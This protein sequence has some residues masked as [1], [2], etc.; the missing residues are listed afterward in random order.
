[1]FRDIGVPHLVKTRRC[2]SKQLQLFEKEHPGDS[3][4]VDVKIV[5]CGRDA[6]TR[7]RQL[8]TCGW[9]GGSGGPVRATGAGKEMGRPR[10]E[11]AVSA[12]RGG[13]PRFLRRR[14]EVAR[15]TP[16][17]PRTF[18][19]RRGRAARMAPDRAP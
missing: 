2:R 10:E 9:P 18:R 4:Q 7:P 5:A 8:A 1:V 13:A 11:L 15:S 16:R 19:R 6:H 3:V 17:A 14:S 12:S